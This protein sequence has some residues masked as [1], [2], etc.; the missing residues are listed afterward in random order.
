MA[1]RCLKP[2]IHIGRGQAGHILPEGRPPR[3]GQQPIERDQGSQ[4]GL[5]RFR[6]GVAGAE[7]DEVLRHE[8]LG[9]DTDKG[10]PVKGRG[11]GAR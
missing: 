5:Q 11:V 6:A 9:A 8:V 2:G 1:L 3:W 7:V 4:G 10:Q